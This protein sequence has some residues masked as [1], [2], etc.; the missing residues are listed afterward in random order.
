MSL[1]MARTSVT[2]GGTMLQCPTMPGTKLQR[3]VRVTGAG[4][5]TSSVL[6]RALSRIDMKI[7]AEVIRLPDRSWSNASPICP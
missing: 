7:L 2:E 6:S 4:Q 1:Q 5:K 3:A